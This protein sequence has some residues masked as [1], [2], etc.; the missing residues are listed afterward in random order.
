MGWDE[1][2]VLIIVS[3]M[4]EMEIGVLSV[5]SGIST[6]SSSSHLSFLSSLSPPL[7]AFFGYI[8]FLKPILTVEFYHRPKFLFLLCDGNFF[9]RSTRIRIFLADSL[10]HRTDDNNNR[11]NRCLLGSNQSFFF[12]IF[13]PIDCACSSLNIANRGKDLLSPT[14][15]AASPTSALLPS[16]LLH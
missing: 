11:G 7:P 14:L 6:S 1:F 3:Q 13:C 10:F 12:S 5:P 9:I 8:W 4:P 2:M 16:P 15:P